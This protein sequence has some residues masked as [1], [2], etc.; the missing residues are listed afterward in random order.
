LKHLTLTAITYS[1][2]LDSLNVRHLPRIHKNYT[3]SNPVLTTKIK[4]M[5]NEKYWNGFI[6]GFFI[7]G[8]IGIFTLSLIIK[9][10]L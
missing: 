7:G 8:I 10:T 4:I 2:S 3:G 5:K 6:L 9:G 1:K